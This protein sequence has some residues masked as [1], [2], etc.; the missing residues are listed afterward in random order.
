MRWVRIV[1]VLW[2][3]WVAASAVAQGDVGVFPTQ[4]GAVFG[5]QVEEI[6]SWISRQEDVRSTGSVGYW[7]N[8]VDG[9]GAESVAVLRLLLNRDVRIIGSATPFTHPTVS[10]ASLAT[11]VSVETDGAGLTEDLEDGTGD[12]ASGF[13]DAEVVASK[14]VGAG[15][16]VYVGGGT[17]SAGVSD[18]NP[19]ATQQ[20]MG[21][22]SS[23][24]GGAGLR[25]STYSLGALLE[26]GALIRHVPRDGAVVI[27]VRVQGRNGEDFGADSDDTEAPDLA[28]SVPYM[29]S[30]QLTALP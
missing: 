30:V 12:P 11:F 5:M 23:A 24:R 4:D 22:L 2:A 6:V 3:S 14:G 20:R 29:A 15:N 8:N 7:D 26:G 17:V 18:A 1:C 13:P 10:Q 28:A 27:T 9:A 19:W 21:E 16:F 25:A